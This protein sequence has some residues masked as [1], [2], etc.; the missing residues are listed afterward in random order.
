MLVVFVLHVAMTVQ[1][2]HSGSLACKFG[3]ADMHKDVWCRPLECTECLCTIMTHIQRHRTSV[4]G[5]NSNSLKTFINP[6]NISLAFHM[7]SA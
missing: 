5:C 4:V 1:V 3:M 2:Q 7:F 6:I